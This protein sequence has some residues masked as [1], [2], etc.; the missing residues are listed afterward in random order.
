M[1]II[2]IDQPSH[3]ANS[4]FAFWRR[5]MPFRTIRPPQENFIRRLMTSNSV[6]ERNMQQQQLLNQHALTAYLCQSN[7]FG[8]FSSFFRNSQIMLI[9]EL[10]TH[11]TNNMNRFRDSLKSAI[12]VKSVG[13]THCWRFC[14]TH[15]AWLAYGTKQFAIGSVYFIEHEMLILC[16]K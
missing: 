5:R 1:R 13:D 15:L 10:V 4:F 6:W 16:M 8:F 7:Y 3:H 12:A 11:L 2:D 9:L 14:F